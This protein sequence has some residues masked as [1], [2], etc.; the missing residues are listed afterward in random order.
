MFNEMHPPSKILEK[1]ALKAGMYASLKPLP[2]PPNAMSA[3]RIL[4]CSR[5]KSS[6]QSA[7]NGAPFYRQ[8]LAVEVSLGEIVTR[9]LSYF[10]KRPAWSRP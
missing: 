2:K 4:R 7:Y 9:L 8:M 6:S 3:S 10:L 5:Q 1:G